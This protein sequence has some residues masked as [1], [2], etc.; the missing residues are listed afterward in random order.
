[1]AL[2]RRGKLLVFFLLMILVALLAPVYGEQEQEAKNSP[3]KK[4]GDGMVNKR[5]RLSFQSRNQTIESNPQRR[6]SCNKL[7]MTPGKALRRL[8]RLYFFVNA[9]RLEREYNKTTVKEVVGRYCPY[10]RVRVDIGITQIPM[11]D[12]TAI[13][14]NCSKFC[15]PVPYLIRVLRNM[16]RDG[17]TGLEKW[18]QVEKKITVAYVF[19]PVN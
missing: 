15:K 7:K 12:V 2:S 19:D 17:K 6:G 8:Q 14:P 10:K 1:M 5:E 3:S 13:C 4:G 9:F 16:G 18:I 11:I